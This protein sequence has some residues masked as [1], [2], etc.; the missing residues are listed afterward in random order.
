MLL[1][2]IA[3]LIALYINLDNQPRAEPR[4]NL[5]EQFSIDAEHE[6]LKESYEAE[7]QP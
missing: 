3:V 4:P 2:F 7:F 1:I 5:K 6:S